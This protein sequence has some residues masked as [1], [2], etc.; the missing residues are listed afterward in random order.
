MTDSNVTM[1]QG[2]E[3]LA[4]FG[5]TPADIKE[6]AR[7][8]LSAALRDP[9][10]GFAIKAGMI[11]GAYEAFTSAVEGAILVER[12]KWKDAA[13]AAFDEGAAQERERCAVRAEAL[14]RSG[15]EWVKDSLWANIK[16][17]TAAA[18]RRGDT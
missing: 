18:I 12:E 3:G 4:L 2:T 15:R 1:P 13:E 9:R 14:D 10:T 6:A 8:A 16:R 5:S 11:G 7:L 17:D